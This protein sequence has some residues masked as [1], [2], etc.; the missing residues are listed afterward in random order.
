MSSNKAA[1]TE[2]LPEDERRAPWR[3]PRHVAIAGLAI[4]AVVQALAFA[5]VRAHT[6]GPSPL[7]TR[8]DD[9]SDLSLRDSQGA[10][11][12][13]GAGQP[14]LLL[15]FDPDCAH[16]RRVAPFWTSWLESNVHKGHRIIA[17]STG[18]AATDY[19]DKQQWPVIVTSTE[20]V[21]HE[22]TKRSPWVFAVDGQ[23]RVVADGHGRHLGEVAS[24]LV[25]RKPGR[26]L[27]SRPSNAMPSPDLEDPTR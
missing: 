13:L 14:T 15:V 1:N 20:P 25:A 27:G 26:E 24:Q 18:P 2:I 11:Q 22:I 6:N 3:R 17:I 19:V 4:V 23:G 9:I 5:Y 21:G 16:S 8:G 7:V 12:E 10:L